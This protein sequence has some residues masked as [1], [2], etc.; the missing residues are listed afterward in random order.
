MTPLNWP[1]TD[2]QL[3]ELL[4]IQDGTVRQHRRI[5]KKDL[6]EGVHYSLHYHDSNSRDQYLWLEEGGIFLARH[7]RQRKAKEFLE[8]LGIAVREKSH[9]ESDTI[10]IIVN[11]LDGILH[12]FKKEHYVNGFRVDLY[13]PEIN[14]AI[15]CD[16]RGHSN[17]PQFIEEYREDTI[18]NNLKCTFLRY[19]PDEPGFNIGKVVNKLFKMVLTIKK[20]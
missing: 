11:S 17:Y 5:N 12:D 10:S 8:L 16:E 15:E 14:V 19:N 9:I 4:G 13:L 2:Q 6:I 1:M 18:S 7:C 20:G 3:A